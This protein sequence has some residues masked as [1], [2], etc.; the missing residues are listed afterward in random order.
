MIL[1]N[2]RKHN[3]TISDGPSGLAQDGGVD[4]VNARNSTLLIRGVEEADEGNYTCFV[5]GTDAS[6]QVQLVVSPGI[7][8]HNTHQSVILEGR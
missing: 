7:C 4:L 6:A 2:S 1:T 8:Q 5:E 3:I